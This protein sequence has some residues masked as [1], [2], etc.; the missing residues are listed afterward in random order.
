MGGTNSIAGLGMITVF[1]MNQSNQVIHF[2]MIYAINL[3]ENCKDDKLKIQ[4]CLDGEEQVNQ[5]FFEKMKILINIYS[6][7]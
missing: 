4:E 5:N 6:Y 2:F 1:H 7:V 3:L